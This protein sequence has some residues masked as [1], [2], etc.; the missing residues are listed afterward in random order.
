MLEEGEGGHV[1]GRLS[2]LHRGEERRDAVPEE[3]EE[4]VCGRGEGDNERRKAATMGALRR[5]MI[6]LIST[7]RG[8]IEGDVAMDVKMSSM[9][10]TLS[11][12]AVVLRNVMK[13][14]S[15]TSARPREMA[16]FVCGWRKE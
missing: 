9:A 14:V 13:T 8:T 15:M 3:G 11:P 16:L 6:S 7:R 12:D 2:R 10:M 4:C 5:R 1:Q